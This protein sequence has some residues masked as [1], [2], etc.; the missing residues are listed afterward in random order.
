MILDAMLPQVS[1]L[2][3]EPAICELPVEQVNADSD[4]KSFDEMLQQKTPEQNQKVEESAEKISQGLLTPP[5]LSF[6]EEVEDTEGVENDEN[7]IENLGEKTK[8]EEIDPLLLVCFCPPPV[9]EKVNFQ[10][11]PPEAVD[12]EV[13]P[14]TQPAPLELPTEVAPEIATAVEQIA[15]PSTEQ[16]N[17][18]VHNWARPAP[19]SRSVERAKEPIKASIAGESSKV[20]E[21]N[22]T[23]QELG[24]IFT[25]I[26][27]IQATAPT[28]DPE[29]MAE[30]APKE[31]GTPD[32][33][34]D[35]DMQFKTKQSEIAALP[36][37]KVVE[38]NT[39]PASAFPNFSGVEK[40]EGRFEVQSAGEVSSPARANRIEASEVYAA[41]RTEIS[42]MR[43]FQAN[44]MALVLRPDQ[45][46]E[47]FIRLEIRHGIVEAHARCEKGDFNSLNGQWG[48]LQETLAGQGVRLA[49]LSDTTGSFSGHS[50]ERNLEQ[51]SSREDQNDTPEN[52][53]QE[54]FLNTIKKHLNS[55]PVSSGSRMW[56]GWA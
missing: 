27:G 48:Q 46:T 8:S 6:C 14:E 36:E 3:K 23:G 41:L 38:K 1:A 15:A 35:F 32:A 12:F 30:I 37:T 40:G 24:K 7:S 4:P 11:A 50:R 42:K 47:L 29:I 18:A 26:V 17:E 28:K 54:E 39:D 53:D 34:Q 55:N 21:Q 45:D 5:C 33:Q 49:D 52:H 19:L 43:Q 31:G 25:P 22:P 20:R 2:Q 9:I 56:Q 10:M 44:N 16:I 13:L 51:H